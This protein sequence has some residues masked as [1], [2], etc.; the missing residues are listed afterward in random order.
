LI[1]SYDHIWLLIEGEYR[2][3]PTDGVLEYR[4]AGRGGGMFWDEAGGGKRRWLWRDFQ[5]WL[6]SMSVLGGLRVQQCRDWNEGAQWIKTAYNWFQR[7]EHKS[8]Q[9]V[10]SGKQLYSDTALLVKPSLARRVAKELP[11][12][13]VSKSRDVAASFPT[14]Q[15][16]VDASEKEWAQVP[17]IG[18]KL[19][20]TIWRSLRGG[21]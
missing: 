6:L 3:R 5:G 21:V 17:G 14:V 15:Q 18:R 16:M 12:I 9:V 1:Q 13:G 19:A 20:N 8:V 7:D 2:A 11:S 10:Y 4:R